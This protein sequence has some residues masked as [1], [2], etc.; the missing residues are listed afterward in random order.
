MASQKRFPIDEFQD[1]ISQ[2]F[3]ADL[4]NEQLLDFYL[5]SPKELRHEHFVD[6]LRAAEIAGVT[7][8]TIQLWIESEV[9][10]AI[11]I[12]RKYQ[13]SLVSLKQFLKRRAAKEP[14]D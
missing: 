8:R 2:D 12:G 1:H 10:R 11:R 4:T 3:A 6:T 14:L 7:Q 5:S 13:V 9:I